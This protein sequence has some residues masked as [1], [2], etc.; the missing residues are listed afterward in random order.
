MYV[1][2]ERDRQTDRQTGSAKIS[3]CIQ[4]LIVGSTTCN[5]TGDT[6]II[7]IHSERCL[8]GCVCGVR[9]CMLKE[10]DRQY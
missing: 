8:Y 3:G 9:M 4:G 7:T 6:R 10:T 5:W 1:Y 2:V